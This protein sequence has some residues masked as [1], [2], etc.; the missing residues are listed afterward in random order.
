MS[1]VAQVQ[2]NLSN[3]WNACLIFLSEIVNTYDVFFQSFFFI[4]YFLPSYIKLSGCF[5]WEIMIIWIQCCVDGT[6]DVKSKWAV[7][8]APNH[9]TIQKLFKRIHAV[10]CF[11]LG[12]FKTYCTLQVCIFS[13]YTNCYTMF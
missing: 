1:T 4:C 13:K 2:W 12:Y 3:S 5:D 11:Y 6:G 7:Y 9:L 10:S 8:V